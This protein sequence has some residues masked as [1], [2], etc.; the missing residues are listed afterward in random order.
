MLR[1]LKNFCLAWV[2]PKF[3]PTALRVAVVVGSLLALINHGE[4][5]WHREMTHSRWLAVI[6]TYLVPYTVNIHGQFSVY[7]RLHR[8]SSP[9]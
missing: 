1:N 6:F 5:I 9:S 3:R 4:A 7:S 2:D 8:S